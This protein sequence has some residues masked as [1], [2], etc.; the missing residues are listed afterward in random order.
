MLPGYRHHPGL[1]MTVSEVAHNPELKHTQL[2]SAENRRIGF[3][4]IGAV[5]LQ[6][7]APACSKGDESC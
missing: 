7:P 5:R 1:A 4:S 2:T 6:S 3:E